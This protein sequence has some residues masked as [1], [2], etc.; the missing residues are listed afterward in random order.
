[1]LLQ[2][3]ALRGGGGE[4]QPNDMNR[5][6]TNAAMDT[7]SDGFSTEA[8]KLSPQILQ[9]D[10]QDD[11]PTT[12]A[13]FLEPQ[14]AE[15]ASRSVLIVMDAFCP[16]HGIYLMEQAMDA[17]AMVVPVLS[18]YLRNFLLATEPEQAAQ[19]Q[20]MRMPRN[21]HEAR[22]WLQQLPYASMVKAVYCES[23]SGL[24]NAEQ[25]RELLN[26]TCQDEPSVLSARR[27]KFLKNQH[28]QEVTAGRVATAQQQLCHTVDQAWDF[29]QV[30]W[31]NIQRGKEQHCVV[32]KPVRGVASE[33]VYLCHTHAEV[34]RAFRAITNTT[35]FGSTRARDEANETSSSSPQMHD[36]VLV[37]EYLQG[38]EY[39]LD[40]VSRQGQHKIAAIW[41]YDKRPA[42]GAPFCYFQTQ[43]VDAVMEPVNVPLIQDYV[44]PVLDALGIRYGLS[45]VEVIMVEEEEAEDGEDSITTIER[46]PVLVEVNCRQHNMD[47]LPIVMACIG[48]NALDMTLAALL[49]DENNNNEEGQGDSVWD[50]Y[51]DEPIVRRYGCMVHLVN[52]VQ[53]VLRQVRYM[54]EMS[55]LPSFYR[56][57]LYQAFQPPRPDDDDDDMNNNSNA[58][59]MGKVARIIEPTRDI[60]S[61]AGWVQ[62]I[63]DDVQQVDQDYQQIVEWMPDMF[64]VE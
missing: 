12:M 41:K 31:K 46:R 27:H 26:V 39:A 35:V 62:L 5:P 56:G 10:D 18:D 8:A 30:L 47:F 40:I 61:D 59:M 37:Q 54:E 63:H 3:S 38:T 43:L 1:M 6:R 57:Q 52:Y 58:A 44:R 4:N 48:Y 34:E 36:S 32:I 15:Q 2:R 45:H 55:Q 13:A 21:H 53:G 20:A 7:A 51:P 23:D 22:E 29:C 64:Q 19:W 60:R 33:S 17:G 28:I 49:E 9:R 24:D 11:D 50:M 42:N 14:P 25:L 16:Y